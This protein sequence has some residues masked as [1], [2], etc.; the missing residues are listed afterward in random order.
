M[1]RF[2]VGLPGVDPTANDNY[3][4]R[5]AAEYAAGPGRL[6]V[7]RFLLSLDRVRQTLTK[8]KLRM[9]ERMVQ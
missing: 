2:L 1:V 6:D 9:Y 5:W 8:E 4:I 7:V 3:P